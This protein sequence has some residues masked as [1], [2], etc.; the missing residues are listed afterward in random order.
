MAAYFESVGCRDYE[1]SS[2]YSVWSVIRKKKKKK[3]KETCIG[4]ARNKT[5]QR[6][7]YCGRKGGRGETK[8][9]QDG[10]NTR[11]EIIQQMRNPG[12]IPE[13]PFWESRPGRITSPHR[14]RPAQRQGGH[15]LRET[16]SRSGVDGLDPG[17]VWQRSVASQS[18]V[19]ELRVSL[20][21]VRQAIMCS[22]LLRK[23]IVSGSSR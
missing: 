11:V 10:T 14:Q 19:S 12:I 15:I 7:A 22:A 18:S 3:G 23:R 5:T 17:K 6:K 21:V 8:S 20:H 13:R 16:L 4:T 2:L 9:V 1:R